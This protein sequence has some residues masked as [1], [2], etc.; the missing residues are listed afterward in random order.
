MEETKNTKF[1]MVQDD[2]IIDIQVSGYYYKAVQAILIRKGETIP[3]A[4]FIEMLQR[5]NKSEQP[6]SQTEAEIHILT[7][8]V[9]TIEKAAGDQKKVEWY[10]ISLI[11]DM[12]KKDPSGN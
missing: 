4:E 9:L 8:L 3:K 2:A 12:F 10:D 1:P 11:E 5:L 7:A 6:K